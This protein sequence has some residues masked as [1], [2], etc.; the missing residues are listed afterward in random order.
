MIRLQPFTEADYDRLIGWIKS[1]E[2]LIQFAGSIFHFPITHQQLQFYRMPPHRQI[3]K[4]VEAESGEIIGH[5]EIG[6]I[7]KENGSAV[8]CR[9][10]IGEEKHRGKGYGGELVRQLLMLC[11]DS[12]KL[13]RVELN[14]YDFNAAAIACYEKQGFVKEGLMRD[15]TR[16]GD[17]YWSTWRMSILEN[18]W[19]P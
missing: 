5:G 10:L 15:A 19:Q 1:E 18:E 12:L 6:N 16:V 9:L 14:V 17:K 3:Y 4:V 8:L 2:E 13:H 11:F 7:Q